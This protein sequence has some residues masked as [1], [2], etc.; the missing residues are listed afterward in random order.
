VSEDDFNGRTD[1]SGQDRNIKKIP[2][3]EN[4]RFPLPLPA[5]L[6]FW[7]V[8]YV[9]YIFGSSNLVKA[10]HYMH[11]HLYINIYRLSLPIGCRIVVLFKGRQ[12]IRHF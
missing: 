8:P 5:I 1:E 7:G 11:K 9:P 12:G 6:I 10:R 2:L 3:H 4:D